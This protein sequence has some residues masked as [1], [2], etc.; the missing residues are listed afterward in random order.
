MLFESGMSVIGVD[1]NV[2]KLSIPLKGDDHGWIKFQKRVR[3]EFF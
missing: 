1:K 3:N 2:S